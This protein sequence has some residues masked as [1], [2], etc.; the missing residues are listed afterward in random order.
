MKPSTWALDM[1]RAA[2]LSRRAALGVGVGAAAAGLAGSGVALA[3][4]TAVRP[5]LATPE[6]IDAER[7][8]LQL[9]RDPQVKALKA[10]IRAE[11]AATPRGQ[12]PDA[13]A[14]LHEAVDQWTNSLIIK[15]ITAWRAPAIIWGT[16]DT[17][18]T[19]L[20]HTLGGVGTSGD[21]PDNI[22]RSAFIDGGGSYEITGRTNLARRPAQFS[23]EV[24]RGDGGLPVKLKDQ[25]RG[26]ADLGNQIAMITDKDLAIGPDG[27]FR[28]TLGGSS[29]GPNQVALEPGQ[30]TLG[31]RDTLSDWRQRPNRLAL[32]RL[33]AAPARTSE[34]AEPRR[35][36]LAKLEDYIRFW[37]DFPNVW[38]GGL[39]PNGHA[40]PIPRDGGWGFLAGLRYRLAPDEAILVTTTHGGA[41][42]TGFQVVDPWMIA[43]DARRHLASLNLSQ[44]AA[45]PDGSFTYVIARTDPGVANWLDTAGLGEGYGILRWQGLPPGATK[46]GLLRDF[47][48]VRLSELA[49]APGLVRVTPAE[50]RA[51][52][53]ARVAGYTSRLT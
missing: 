49:N 44:A 14:R 1:R 12:I 52:L 47:R 16:D 46:D 3:G 18:R 8:L 25:G 28:I 22:Y 11:L 21:N 31:F 30:V 39:E 29:G 7:R 34:P 15:E 51:Q 40:G 9:L 48:V 43:P 13:A 36:V 23:L 26:H 5:A 24:V 2:V 10:K 17:P 45:G 50:R 27:A 35:R 6:Q 32:R 19:W 37:S 41:R 53:A 33:D 4:A 38:F 42:Y 20:G